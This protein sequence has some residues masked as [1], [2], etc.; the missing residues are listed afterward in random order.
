MPLE[1]GL[2]EGDV[3]DADAKFVASNLLDAIDQQERIT[4]RKIFEN[5]LRA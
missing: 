2:I 4:M 5:L 1:A 3:L